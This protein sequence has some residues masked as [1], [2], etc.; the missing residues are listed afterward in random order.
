MAGHS[1]DVAPRVSPSEDSVE[2]PLDLASVGAARRWVASRLA[3]WGPDG[4][5]MACL[6]ASELVANVMLHARTP[7]TL[8]LTGGDGSCRLSV[9][10]GDPHLP[11]IKRY[12]SD[13]PTGRGL[14][15]VS[16]LSDRWGFEHR[17][18]GKVVWAELSESA[19]VAAAMAGEDAGPGKDPVV[20]AEPAPEPA[21]DNPAPAANPGAA[22]HPG[23]A[24]AG[25]PAG[26]EWHEA[27]VRLL[28]AP[29]ALLAEAQQHNDE[30][31]REFAFLAGTSHPISVRLKDLAG[32]VQ[33]HFRPIERGI[34][35]TI[36]GA[37]SEGQ[38]GVDLDVTLSRSGWAALQSL[39]ELLDEA[40]AFCERME[41]LTLTS[42][43]GVRRL[44]HWY[45]AEVRRQL[46]GQPPTPWAAAP[47]A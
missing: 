40:D 6:L 18:P 41:L 30:L 34:R 10:D 46:D 43:P 27:A 8:Q 33:A 28:G 17:P 13:A 25:A 12:G 2:L 47:P 20:P 9:Y 14:V 35:T 21:A 11:V 31:M 38:A 45:T 1:P 24:G 3:G 19:L 36:A 4:R 44:R 32:E 5:G 42:S 26:G 15:L 29:L 16:R 7:V 39:S 23:A 22:A 37:E